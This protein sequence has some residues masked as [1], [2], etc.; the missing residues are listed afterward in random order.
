MARN[1]V[2]EGDGVSGTEGN[3]GEGG[4]MAL[5]VL[6]KNCRLEVKQPM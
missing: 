2:R 3:R 6:Y 5:A 1:R 4:S